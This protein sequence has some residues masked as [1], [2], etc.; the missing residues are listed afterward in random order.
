V[1]AD[2]WMIG[3]G[4]NKGP[5]H[6][7]VPSCDKFDPPCVALDPQP[8]AV[9]TTP[10]ED[11]PDPGGP[12]RPSIGDR[13]DVR[14]VV[15]EG[16]EFDA[17]TLA[18]MAPAPPTAAPIDASSDY[19][20]RPLDARSDGEPDAVPE[21]PPSVDDVIDSLPP[22]T[23]DVLA[24]VNKS[25]GPVGVNGRIDPADVRRIVAAIL[26]VIP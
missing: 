3:Q 4:G 21:V 17:V 16:P 10:G 13:E 14:R 26:G 23:W 19:T 2:Q 7:W 15:M 11:Q 5:V 20:E 22:R 8:W 25:G 1:S 24:W 18:E 9:D 12:M 6:L